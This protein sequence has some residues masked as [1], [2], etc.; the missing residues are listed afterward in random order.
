MSDAKQSNLI[1]AFE[2]V[3]ALVGFVAFVC[4]SQR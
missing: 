4:L 1:A 3:N 2:F